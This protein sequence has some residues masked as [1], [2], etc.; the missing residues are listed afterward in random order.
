MAHFAKLDE[1]NVVLEVIVVNNNELMMDNVES[2]EKGIK[3]LTETFGPANWKKTSCNTHDGVYYNPEDATEGDQSKAFRVN[4]GRVGYS[5]NT[6]HDAFISPPPIDYTGNTADSWLPNTIS[7]TFVREVPYPPGPHPTPSNSN[8]FYY[9]EE[10]KYKQDPNTGW[11]LFVIN[12][13]PEGNAIVK[14]T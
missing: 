4:F 12:E 1:N 14:L 13:F 2:E 10:S 5:Y 6:M 11:T 9:W 8:S 3:F 7:G